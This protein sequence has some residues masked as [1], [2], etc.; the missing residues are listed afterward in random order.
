MKVPSPIE[1]SAEL[2]ELTDIDMRIAEKEKQFKTEATRIHR[3][4]LGM[5]QDPGKQDRVNALLDGGENSE[6]RSLKEQLIIAQRNWGDAEDAR[7][8]NGRKIFSA[9]MKAMEAIRKKLQPDRDRLFSDLCERI[10]AVRESHV[11]FYAL[12]AEMTAAG[13]SC[14]DFF[15]TNADFLGP[16]SS[17]VSQMAWFLQEAKRQGAISSLP[18][19]LR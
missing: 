14:G 19:D 4:I 2:K 5:E 15:H 1:V 8:Q 12:Q 6:L 10:L 7:E 11:A 16:P 3:I 17:K 13:V 18:K 9:R